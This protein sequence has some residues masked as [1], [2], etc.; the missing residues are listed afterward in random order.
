MELEPA[1]TTV[2]GLFKDKPMFFIP[3]Y[4]R[5]YAWENE[6]VTDFIKDLGNCFEK[7]KAKS[8]ISHFFGGILS[9]ESRVPGMAMQ[10]E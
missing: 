5:A 8:P 6:S 9:V 1:Y 2:G 10:H 7:R 4:Q 3:K